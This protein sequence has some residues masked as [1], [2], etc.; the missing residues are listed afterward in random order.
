MKLL[1]SVM[2]A[3]PLSGRTEAILSFYP[4][5][6]NRL[7]SECCMGWVRCSSTCIK[8]NYLQMA[9]K[10]LLS[11]GLQDE[12]L[13]VLIQ[14]DTGHM[15]EGRDSQPCVLQSGTV[16]RRRI[17]SFS[18]LVSVHLAKVVISHDSAAAPV[19]RTSC[20]RF[21]ANMEYWEETGIRTG[22]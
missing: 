20:S 15:V 7:Y 16:G 17:F 8:P 12:A 18:C 1:G 11:F 6:L 13:Q 2:E 19:G 22:I 10:W 3:V 14:G 5:G 21:G 4:G 9:H